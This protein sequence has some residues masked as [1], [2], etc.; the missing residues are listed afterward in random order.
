MIIKDFYVLLQLIKIWGLIKKFFKGEKKMENQT[1]SFLQSKKVKV[2]LVGIVSLI[3]T[4]FLGLHPDEVE[5]L[6]K[7]IVTLTGGYLTAET[8]TDGVRAVKQPTVINNP[9]I[10]DK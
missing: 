4:Q 7:A 1:K 3:A 9:N 6:M 8:V 5:M 10:D 2:F